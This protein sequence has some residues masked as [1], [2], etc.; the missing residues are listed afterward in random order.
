MVQFVRHAAEMGAAVFAPGLLAVALMEL[1]LIEAGVGC[2][3]ECALM[4]PVMLG[5]MLYRRTEYG[6]SHRPVAD[7]A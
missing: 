4:I 6:A 3:V 1:A 2:G 7:E 5:L